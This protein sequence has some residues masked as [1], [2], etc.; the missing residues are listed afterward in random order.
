MIEKLIN[1]N[2]DNII[3]IPRTILDIFRIFFKSFIISPLLLFDKLPNCYMV[4][5]EKNPVK[6][7]L[8]AINE[9]INRNF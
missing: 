8:F 7:G 3:T 9:M 4:K 2:V 6:T 5:N 1:I